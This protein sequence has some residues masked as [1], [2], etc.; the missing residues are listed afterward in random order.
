[1][2]AA[3]PKQFRRPIILGLKFKL[4]FKKKGSRLLSRQPIQRDQD[5]CL[6]N[7]SKG[8]K[9]IVSSTA[10]RRSQNNN[11]SSRG[12]DISQ[13]GDDPAAILRKSLQS[14]L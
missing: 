8:I 1:M 2:A 12:N 10:S 11:S 4:F 7:P 6:V 14:S 5:Y 9:T 3:A 13:E